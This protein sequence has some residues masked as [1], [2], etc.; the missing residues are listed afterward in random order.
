VTQSFEKLEKK[1]NALYEPE[2][3]TSVGGGGKSHCIIARVEY[4]LNKGLRIEKASKQ[5]IDDSKYY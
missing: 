1:V 2:V 4:L 3:R 5:S